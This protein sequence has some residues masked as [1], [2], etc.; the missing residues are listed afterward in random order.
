M[1]NNINR[2]EIAE[3]VYFSS[4]RDS[5][6]KINRIAVAFIDTL[7]RKTASL[8]VLIPA[9]LCR[10]NSDYKTMFELNRRLSE[11][12]ST[13]LG[14][15]SSKVGDIERFGVF[16][17]SIDDRFAFDGENVLEEAALLLRDC[18]FNPNLENGV[19]PENTTAIQ[20]QNLMD[21]NDNEINDKALYTYRKG[22]EK[23]FFGE[24]ASVS[25]YGEN[26]DIE[27]ITPETAYKRY[28]EILETKNVEIFCVGPGDFSVVQDIFA[29]AFGN[30]KR[31]PEPMPKTYISNIKS[32]VCNSGEN[33]DVSQSKLLMV[34]KT[35]SK[36][37]RLAFSLMSNI[38]GGDF[39]SKLFS[40][41]REKLSLCYYCHSRYL[42]S[43]GALTVECGVEKDNIEKAKN[44]ILEQLEEI[45][46][47]NFTDED[48]AK[49]KLSMRNNFKS[50][51]DRITGIANWYM[52]NIM[53]GIDGTP[54]READGTDAVT[55]ERIIEAANSIKLDTVFVLT[56]GEEENS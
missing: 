43:K 45:R 6:F 19:F 36:E 53:L 33:M 25:I 1:S 56:S 9:L 17:D 22:I 3:G 28:L 11:L 39:S 40:V 41:V 44:A 37:D 52:N 46:S 21:N 16:T 26:E 5:R 38:F 27:K 35:D 31:N 13:S 23:A 34:F 15:F 54:E 29:E 42:T 7:D 51:G 14:D 8:N 10:T 50:V 47:G 18:I 4:Y 55:R 2:K 48:M 20:K 30:I 49:A 12:Y 24:P 32:D